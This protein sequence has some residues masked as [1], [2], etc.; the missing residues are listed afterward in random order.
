MF[1]GC[2]NYTEM[3]RLVEVTVNLN[4]SAY[5]ELLDDQVL[6][7]AHHLIEEHKIPIQAHVLQSHRLEVRLVAYSLQLIQ[8][9]PKSYLPLFLQISNIPYNHSPF[10]KQLP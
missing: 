8:S 1:W 7:F 10:Y 3:G 5:I 2:F 4:H 6:P 9:P